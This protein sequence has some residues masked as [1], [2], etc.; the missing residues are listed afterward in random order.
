MEENKEKYERM[1]TEKDFN[2][3]Q[4]AIKGG[5]ESNS[6]TYEDIVTNLVETFK[7]K[8]AV[9]PI[10]CIIVSATMLTSKEMMAVIEVLK[11]TLRGKLV[12]EL[13]EKADKG[14]ATSDDLALAM[15]LALTNK[16]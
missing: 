3:A 14:E 13:R 9:A 11:E 7:D 4:E 16:K 2:H 5:K 6:L 8:T 12:E 15:M 1:I 10:E